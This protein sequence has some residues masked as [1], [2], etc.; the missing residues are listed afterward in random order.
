MRTGHPGLPRRGA[1]KTRVSFWHGRKHACNGV[2]TGQCPGSTICGRQATNTHSPTRWGLFLIRDCT[3]NPVLM[4]SPSATRP[5]IRFSVRP[6]TGPW[7]YRAIWS[8]KRQRRRHRRSAKSAKCHNTAKKLYYILRFL[9][10][11]VLWF[12]III[13][14]AC[15]F[16]LCSPCIMERTYNTMYYVIIRT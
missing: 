14:Y 6:A 1:W 15:V 10:Y 11:G 5:G 9:Y 7:P 3:L 13:Y 8:A 2:C 4:P 12:Y 16:V